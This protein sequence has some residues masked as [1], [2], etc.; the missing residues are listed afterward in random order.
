LER[1]LLKWE[2]GINKTD[3]FNN[4]NEET[5][6]K[7]FLGCLLSVTL[8][9][10]SIQAASAEG[11]GYW[12]RFTHAVSYPFSGAA[13]NAAVEEWFKC[14]DTTAALEACVKEQI[15]KGAFIRGSDL[16][17][18]LNADGNTRLHALV[19]AKDTNLD[20]GLVDCLVK[21][22][23]DINFRNSA[24][25]TPLLTLLKEKDITLNDLGTTVA[26]LVE[27][28]ADITAVTSLDKTALH[29]LAGASIRDQKFD[30]EVIGWFLTQ[31]FD[32][33]GVRSFVNAQDANGNT[34]LH[35][36]A[37]RGSLTK[38]IGTFEYLIKELNVDPKVV[39]QFGKTYW[40]VLEDSCFI[41]EDTADVLARLKELTSVDLNLKE[42]P[43]VLD[44]TGKPVTPV[45]GT[46]PGDQKVNNKRRN[47][48]IGLGA[49]AALATL[50]YVYTSN[51]KSKPVKT[52]AA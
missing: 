12:Q 4:V 8:I 26:K 38:H 37:R 42:K 40:Q 9:Q 34:V 35:I 25:D 3:I 36:L 14:D 10:G 13:R 52:A 23:A 17:N 39:N 6:M 50:V 45:A 2:L 21:L 7:K 20:L 49:G 41:G 19:R 51:Q 15:E 31:G 33:A 24:G 43:V 46:T 5:S 27:L 1:V 28:G 18:Q 30:R 48:L 32:E 16:V 44:Q 47:L 11:P 29:I 22:G